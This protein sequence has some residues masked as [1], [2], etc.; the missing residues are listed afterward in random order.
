MMQRSLEMFLCLGVTNCAVMCTFATVLFI[1][2]LN[3]TGFVFA[4][5]CYLEVHMH[6]SGTFFTWYYV[7]MCCMLNW[8]LNLFQSVIQV[9]RVTIYRNVTVS[10]SFEYIEAHSA[11]IVNQETQGN[12][13]YWICRA[14]GISTS[15][16]IF[17]NGPH[18]KQR[19]RRM[20][21]V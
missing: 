16:R 11:I 21:I 3:F 15:H 13:F 8:C 17:R 4:Y 19:Q 14:G 7:I 20:C 12:N 6:R 10:L 1:H 2:K 9:P 18:M 5:F